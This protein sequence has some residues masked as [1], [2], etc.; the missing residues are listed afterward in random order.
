MISVASKY[1]R[2][3]IAEA[4]INK[5]IDFM[6]SKSLTVMHVL[7]TSEFSASALIKLNFDVIFQLPYKDFIENGEPVFI[8]AHPHIACKIMAKRI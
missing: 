2:M 4:L 1:R 5:T 7:C 6:K 3:G 8:P